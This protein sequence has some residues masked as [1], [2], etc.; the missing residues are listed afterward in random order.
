MNMKPDVYVRSWE[1]GLSRLR[2]AEIIDEWENGFR[3][4]SEVRLPN[5][6]GTGY[7]VVEGENLVAIRLGRSDGQGPFDYPAEKEPSDVRPL[8]DFAENAV[9]R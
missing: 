8:P 2:G 4:R 6:P 5:L 7:Y 9:G 3:I 1:N